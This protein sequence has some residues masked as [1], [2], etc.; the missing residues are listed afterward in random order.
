MRRYYQYQLE[1]LYLAALPVTLQ[2]FAFEPQFYAGLSP[3]TG[4]PQTGG[5]GGTGAAIG[6][7][8]FAT[9]T[10]LSTAN[11][12]TYATRFA[13]TGQVSTMNI[14]TVAGMG[15]LFNTRRPAPAGVRQRAGLQLRGQEPAGSRRCSRRCR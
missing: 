1:Q 13:P 12:W 5:A 4:V 7:G 14:G 6:G 3:T 2:R 11:S 10:G 9:A 15:K 8:S